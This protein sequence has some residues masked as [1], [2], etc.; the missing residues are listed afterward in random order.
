M[1]VSVVPVPI[2]AMG[3]VPFIARQ[4]LGAFAVRALE[5][6]PVARLVLAVEL[7]KII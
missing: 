7:F 2:V 4:T 5:L 1:T 3:A 6:G